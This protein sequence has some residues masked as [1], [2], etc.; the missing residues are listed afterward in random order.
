MI[1]VL[2]SYLPTFPFSPSFLFYDCDFC[3]MYLARGVTLSSVTKITVFEP[4]WKFGQ[5][6]WSFIVITQPILWNGLKEN[7][8]R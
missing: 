8:G 1:Y 5:R 2:V 6:A 4:S 7:S 3:D